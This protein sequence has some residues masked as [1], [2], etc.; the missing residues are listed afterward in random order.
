MVDRE[1]L[2]ARLGDADEE[3]RRLAV[4]EVAEGGELEDLGLL[5]DAMGD[6]SWRVRKEASEAVVVLGGP[7]AAPLL[8][9]GLRD[10]ANAG[11]RNAVVEALV[12]LGPAVIPAVGGLLRD[13][14]ADI[15][16]FAVDILG[17]IG[18][19]EGVPLL[20]SSLEDAD[21][22]VLAAAA[23]A[24]GAAGDSRAVE[25]LLGLLLRGGSWLRFCALRAVGLLAGEERQAEVA[26]FL[27]D[28][29]LRGEAV[30]ILAR[31][32]GEESFRRLVELCPRVPLREQAR[33]LEALAGILE[34]AGESGGALPQVLTDI[35]DG[36]GLRAGF[37]ERVARDIAAGE[38]A[39]KRRAIQV[40]GLAPSETTLAALV[41]A[42]EPSEEE[43]RDEICRALARFPER[44][45]PSLYPFLAAES[46]ILRR[47]IAWVFGRRRDRAALSRILPLAKDEDGH[48]RGA[49]AQALGQ[50]GDT[51]AVV[52]LH[53]LLADAY[54]DVREAAAA[55]L[56]G[57]AK[58]DPVV[59]GLVT[60]I[61]VSSLESGDDRRAEGSLHVLGNLGDP[62]LV[63]VFRRF[64]KDARASVRRAALGGLGRIATAEAAETVLSALT[65]EDPDIRVEAIRSL[66]RSGDQGGRSAVRSMVRDESQ[67][68]AAE[69]LRALGSFGGADDRAVLR[70][71]A[72]EYTG[73]RQLVAL[74]ALCAGG[75]GEERDFL[76]GL[77]RAVPPEGRREIVGCLGRSGDA[78]ALPL[79]GEA[80]GDPDW[81]V[82]L[83]AAEALQRSGDRAAAA[84]LAV[85][86]LETEED[87]LV[88]R[89]L[90]SFAG[91]RR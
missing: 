41:A 73:L 69:A 22:N 55:A 61:I 23:E 72:R 79:L 30:A 28:P 86:R 81:S 88:R 9:A 37:D 83:A 60:G 82:R 38:G 84:K 13:P 90:E 80:L 63:G 64:L 32:G 5:V 16:K 51:T 8:F 48:V 76:S 18:T 74:R 67:L 17:G 85:S 29:D 68:V 89:A 24:L 31:L 39:V 7:G 36:S 77:F 43:E 50:I 3:V 6:P 11:R 49:V 4:K 14:D 20:I 12:R 78:A 62:E 27:D 33:I 87:T 70:A 15:R 40:G 35:L 21:E 52:P 10:E 75:G 44:F 19:V 46:T 65:D 1:G 34:R 57:M 58:A 59:R 56:T 2:L 71:A 47:K 66:A 45:L 91:A 25:P 26:A 53:D 54:P 42:I